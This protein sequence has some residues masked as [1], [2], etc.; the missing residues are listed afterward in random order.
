VSDSD[1][2]RCPILG[3]KPLTDV[4]F[5]SFALTLPHKEIYSLENEGG[6]P[7]RQ[8]LRSLETTINYHRLSSDAAYALLLALVE[9]YAYSFVYNARKNGLSF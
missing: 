5:K 9:G 8:Y 6:R 7:L 4:I 2:I 1:L 3:T